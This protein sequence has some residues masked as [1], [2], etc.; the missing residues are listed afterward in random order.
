M[1]TAMA[2]L[3]SKNGNDV[4]FWMRNGKKAYDFNNHRTNSEYL[5]D[6][7]LPEPVR[8][9][10]DLSLALN[11]SDNIVLAIPSYAVQ[12]LLFQIKGKVDIKKARFLS[13][14]KGL[15]GNNCS[16]IS[17]VAEKSLC[18]PLEH[19]AVLSGPN[20]ATELVNNTPSVMV[21]ASKNLQ[22]ALEFKSCIA[23]ERLIV[24]CSTDVAGV[25]I[26]S[27]LK[28]IIAIAM[29]IVDG[30]GFGSNTRGAVFTACI[31]EALDVGTTI[32][33][34]CP[35]TLLGPACLGDSITTG[36]SSKSRNYLLGLLLA[37]KASVGNSETFVCEG[38]N[39]IRMVRTLANERRVSAPVI[40]FVY[41]IT[42]GLNAY[43]SF[44]A[45]WKTLATAD[46]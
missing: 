22:T 42:E 9:T 6:I 32:F 38:K 16:R 20:F 11:Y 28:N 13:V 44:S 25:E 30:L 29:G 3:L 36:F 37:K 14:V 31:K 40:N 8:A 4:L 21:I 35:K 7:T 1:G 27:V 45:L 34:A 12:N 33:G 46:F 43:Q 41:Q 19:F 17:Y 10:S 5:P 18:L 24:Y 23:S 2:Y 26:A 39:N 15:D